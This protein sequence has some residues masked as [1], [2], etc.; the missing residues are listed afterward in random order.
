MVEPTEVMSVT[1]A[2]LVSTYRLECSYN[3]V[4]KIF[5]WYGDREKEKKQK[6]IMQREL[7][8]QVIFMSTFTITIKGRNSDAKV[9][10]G[11]DDKP[12]FCII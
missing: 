4:E 7:K 8:I 2:R 9:C 12:R 5:A 11:N 1:F 6:E 3:T 10:K